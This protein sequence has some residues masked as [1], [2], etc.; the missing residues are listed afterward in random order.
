MDSVLSSTELRRTDAMMQ[1]Q[2]CECAREPATKTCT[3]LPV[4]F[5][6]LG[7]ASAVPSATRNHTANALKFGGETWMIDAGE[8][9]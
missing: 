7:T 6:A 2:A 9:T 4:D 8:A 3:P 1:M 5:I